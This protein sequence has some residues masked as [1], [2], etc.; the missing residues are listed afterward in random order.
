MQAE[1]PAVANLVLPSLTTA[2]ADAT[3]AWRGQAVAEEDPAVAAAMIVGTWG[4]WYALPATGRC[5][6]DGSDDDSLEAAVS[7]PHLHSHPSTLHMRG[8]HMLCKDNANQPSTS[9][10]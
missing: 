10:T 4:M 7:S 2:A 3:R 9:A 6:P 1:C 5:T 8:P